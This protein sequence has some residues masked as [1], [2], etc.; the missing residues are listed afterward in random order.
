MIALVDCAAVEAHWASSNF[1]FNENAAFTCSLLFC[2]L[3]F[4]C[5]CFLNTESLKMQFYIL[6]WAAFCCCYHSQ[7]T[8]SARKDV[9]NQ[10][11]KFFKKDALFGELY[12]KQEEKSKTSAV[13]TRENLPEFSTTTQK[14]EEEVEK[15]EKA[16][17]ENKKEKSV[18]RK[19]PHHINLSKYP[20]ENEQNSQNH[21]NFLKR[22]VARKQWLLKNKEKNIET[23]KDN[24]TK[25][26]S[27]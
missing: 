24:T 9:L 21:Q 20:V 2:D 12:K 7:I 3:S 27:F 16:E 10:F 6:F 18:T 15:T 19:F 13:N 17:T 25:N 8:E 26:T 23:E 4:V 5:C 1:Y 14:S 11:D 22:L